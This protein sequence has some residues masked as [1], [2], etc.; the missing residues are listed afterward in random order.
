MNDELEST[1]KTISQEIKLLQVEKKSLIHRLSQLEE[2]ETSDES[3]N[4][5]GDD[6]N[7]VNY[8]KDDLKMK[9]VPNH[10]NDRYV[11]FKCD[12]CDSVCERAVTLLK[13]QNTKQN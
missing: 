4:K 1:V 10:E 2:L 12:M 11:Y 3:E 13:H 7:V 9:E 6:D 5:S 8:S